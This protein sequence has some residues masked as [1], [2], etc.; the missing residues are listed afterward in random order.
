MFKVLIAIAVLA[1]SLSGCAGFPPNRHANAEAA[2]GCTSVFEA[3]AAAQRERE[4]RAAAGT[5]VNAP[6]E[7]RYQSPCWQASHER[8]ANYD[9][10]FVEF[11]DHGWLSAPAEDFGNSRGKIKWVTDQL[12][13]LARKDGG[14]PLNLVVY[15]H[16][17]HHT[18]APDDGNVDAFRN[19]LDRMSRL[20]KRLDAG[21]AEGAAS[22]SRRVVGVYIGWRGD[23]VLGAGLQQTSIWDRKLAAEEVAQGAVQ[24]LFA[25]L[26]NF[27]LAHA[28]H[29][30]EASALVIA[31]TKPAVP[32]TEDC[33]GGQD[34]HMLTIGHSFGALIT[35]RALAGRLMSNIAEYPRGWSGTG[36]PPYAHSFGDLVVLVNPAFEGVHFEAL[37]RAASERRYP[38]AEPGQGPHGA[39]LPTVIIVQSEGDWATGTFFPLF[40][41]FTSVFSPSTGAVQSDAS[42]HSVGWTDRYV[43]HRLELTQDL[44]QCRLACQLDNEKTW[45]KAQQDTRYKAFGDPSM[46]LANGLNL[47]QCRV[48]DGGRLA[49]GDDAQRAVSGDGGLARPPFMPIWVVRTDSRIIADH[50]DFLN[51]HLLIFVRQIYYTVLEES[52]HAFPD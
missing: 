37:A 20:E 16:G 26:H 15:T 25:R 21:S 11:D 6:D 19:L 9:L 49:C 45:H 3:A 5:P 33:P 2:P 14:A 13:A 40:R 52:L 35:Y 28:C 18:A 27:Y 22:A 10:Y 30:S 44:G 8:T 31:G 23:S 47:T 29:F 39:Q 43:T 46:Q 41:R 34:V 48:A 42:R 1:V 32:R 12:E 24:E 4:Q 50:N 38:T 7:D 17:W 36:A 51:P